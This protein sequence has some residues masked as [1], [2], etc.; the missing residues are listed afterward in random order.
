MEEENDIST[1]FCAFNIIM[2]K[3]KWV[4]VYTI[5]LTALFVSVINLLKNVKRILLITIILKSNDENN[6]Y[7]NK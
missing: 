2:K 6:R 4:C 1:I 5:Q 7:F 3:I